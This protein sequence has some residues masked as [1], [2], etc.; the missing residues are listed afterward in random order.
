MWK[1]GVIG[2]DSRRALR[3]FGGQPC[4]EGRGLSGNKESFVLADR[5]D[6]V[7]G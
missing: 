7:P 2:Q 6:G 3:V 4:A 1:G 5:L